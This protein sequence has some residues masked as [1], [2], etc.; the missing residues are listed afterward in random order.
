MQI[1]AVVFDLDGTLLDSLA[2][3]AQACNAVL[4]THGLPTHAIDEYR[5]LVGDGVR[6]LIT[7]AVPSDNVSDVEA[8]EPWIRQFLEQYERAWNVQ[9]R[10]YDGIPEL[11]RALTDRGVAMT[12]LSNKPQEA[13]RR[14]VDYFLAEFSFAA[15]LGQDAQRPPKPDLTGVREILDLLRLEPAECLYLGDTAVDMQTA[16][17]AGMV[18]VGASWGFRSV[19]ELLAA[20]A[21]AIIDHPRELLP[22]LDGR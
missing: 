13:T 1:R 18:P 22:L 5:Y 11:L 20:G 17:A 21:V 7:R 2:D 9:S 3:I 8:L 6:R 14:C 4:A 19:D 12:V 10:L 16:V 15:V